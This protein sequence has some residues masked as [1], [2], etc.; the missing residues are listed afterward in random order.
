V[1]VSRGRYYKA[2]VPCVNA[3]KV[4][5]ARFGA[6]RTRIGAPGGALAPR[7][8]APCAATFSIEHERI[9]D[10]EEIE[11]QIKRPREK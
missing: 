7:R 4:D 2:L 8:R 5:S 10:E 9:G 1:A 3:A 6:V 11:F